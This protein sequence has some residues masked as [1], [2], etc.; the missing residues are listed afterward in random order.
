MISLEAY[1]EDNPLQAIPAKVLGENLTL[2]PVS[3]DLH[4]IDEYGG[5]SLAEFEQLRAAERR[6]WREAILDQMA[7]KP[8]VSRGGRSIHFTDHKGE[9]WTL[10]EPTLA[11]ERAVSR[12]QK[13]AYDGGRR[14]ISR[15][16]GQMP[17]RVDQL[18]IGEYLTVI[19]FVNLGF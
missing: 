3:R 8:T 18:H 9:E 12:Q 1:L 16:S 11:D 2:D 4:V 7:Y 15:I 19:E 14:M 17:E 13:N 5:P 10:R 6:E